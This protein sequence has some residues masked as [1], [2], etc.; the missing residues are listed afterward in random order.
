MYWWFVAA[1]RAALKILSSAQ[2]DELRISLRDRVA[3]V[4]AGLR[5]A[6]DTQ[7]Q[8]LIVGDERRTMK[9]AESLLDRGIYAQGI[10]PPTVPRGE[11]RLRIALMATH[12]P[13]DVDQLINGVRSSL[14]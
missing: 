6:S 10:R 12:R 5:L 13:E 1:C 7:I 9:V 4:R 3:Q 14:G 11:S 2:G 8:P